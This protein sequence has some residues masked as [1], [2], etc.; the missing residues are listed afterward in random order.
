MKKTIVLPDG[1]PLIG[2]IKDFKKHQELI[3]EKIREGKMDEIDMKF[4]RK[5]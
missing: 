1:H 4:K 2:I 5:Q 3:R